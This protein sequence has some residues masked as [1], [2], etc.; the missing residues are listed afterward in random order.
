MEKTNPIVSVEYLPDAAVVEILGEELLQDEDINRLEES[1]VPLILEKEGGNL[2]LDFT[3]IRLLASSVFG[4]LLKLK[5]MVNQRGGR[6]ILCCVQKKLTNTANDSYVYE[7]F[8]VV[9]LDKV[10][11]ICDDVNTAQRILS[12]HSNA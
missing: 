9:R 2:I 11:T 1:I 12:A 5:K 8:K 6:M 10:F 3:R 4:F 7:I